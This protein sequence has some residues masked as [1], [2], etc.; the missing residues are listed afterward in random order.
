M[1]SVCRHVLISGKVQGVAY[2][3][4]AAERARGLGLTGWIR[5]LKDGRVEA[6]LEG[7]EEHVCEMLD[8]MGRG[9]EAADVQGVHQTVHPSVDA[10]VFQILATP[11]SR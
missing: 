2:R 9:P 1:E 10:V 5:N 4:S 3:F 11:S 8:W 6:V 7:P